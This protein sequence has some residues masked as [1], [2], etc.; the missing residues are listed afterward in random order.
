VILVGHYDYVLGDN[1]FCHGSSC[2]GGNQ[3]DVPNRHISVFEPGG[4]AQ[5]VAFTG[6][7]NTPQGPYG[8]LVGADS[9]YVVGDFTECNGAPQPGFVQFPA[10][11]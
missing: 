10:L 4:G 8:A 9:L 7:L 6:Q 11:R 2:Q 3:G 1:T 5:D